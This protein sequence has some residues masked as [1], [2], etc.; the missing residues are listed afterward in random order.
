MRAP[1]IYKAG[2]DYYHKP[3]PP[4]TGR[5]RWGDF[6]TCQVD[7]CDDMTLWTLQEYAKPR[8]VTANDGTTGSNSSRWSSQWGVVAGPAPSVSIA[9]GPTQS[10][11][12][13]GTTPFVFT[14]NLSTAYSVPGTVNYHTANGSAT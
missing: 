11:G 3:F 14:V 1:F 13:A 9:A 6:T 10:E 5:N 12:N 2:A 7:P 8:T 4:N